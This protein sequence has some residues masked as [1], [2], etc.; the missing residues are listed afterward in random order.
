[1]DYFEYLRDMNVNW[2]GISVALHYDDS[3]DST[4]ERVYSGVITKTFT[5]DFLRKMIQTFLLIILFEEER[6]GNPK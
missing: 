2:V 3:M 6:S 4:V 5:D 1:M